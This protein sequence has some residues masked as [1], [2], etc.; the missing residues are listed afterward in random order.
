MADNYL[1][2]PAY[3]LD[4]K[5]DFWTYILDSQNATQLQTLDN[6][7]EVDNLMYNNQNQ[8]LYF[9]SQDVLYKMEIK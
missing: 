1:S 8:S 2:E 6:Y 4:A 5:Y 9:T 3:D 7:P